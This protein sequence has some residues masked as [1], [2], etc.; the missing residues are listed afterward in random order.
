MINKKLLLSI[1]PLLLVGFLRAATV[2]T[3]TIYSESM[4]KNTRCVVI[5]PSIEKNKV[6]RYPVVYL[7]HGYSG[8][9][10]NWINKVPQVKQYADEYKMIIVCPDGGFSSWYLDSPVDPAMRYETFVGKEV[11]EYI[12]AHYPT[13]R[14][15]KA[16][17]ITG[18]LWRIADRFPSP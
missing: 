12:D 8:N 15:R 2:D 11:P 16:R 14:N 6:M 7:L 4:H 13:L 18:W 9:Y 1:I 10:A 3:I 5:I 17:A